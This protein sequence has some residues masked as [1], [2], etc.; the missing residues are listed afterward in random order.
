MSGVA[1]S[2]TAPSTLLRT[3]KARVADDRAS[4]RDDSRTSVRRLLARGPMRLTRSLAFVATL[5]IVPSAALADGLVVHSRE[6]G[7]WTES[8]ARLERNPASEGQTLHVDVRDDAAHPLECGAYRLALDTVGARAFALGRCDPATGMTEVR[9]F[10]RA[11]LFARGPH[12][13]FQALG[14]RIS[15]AVVPRATDANRV[16]TSAPAATVP[17]QPPAEDPYVDVALLPTIS[18]DASGPIRESRV[19]TTCTEAPEIGQGVT[20]DGT[21]LDGSQRP[22][23]LLHLENQTSVRLDISSSFGGEI[24]IYPACPDGLL[25]TSHSSVFGVG[26]QQRLEWDVRSGD[27]YVVIIDAD[28][29]PHR[30]RYVMRTELQ[31]DYLAVSR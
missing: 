29:H 30:G 6:Y 25:E 1:Q 16:G 31:P 11:A 20:V 24:D 9:L 13:S 7:S 23:Y 18:L 19:A 22:V 15:A 4:I 28:I 12:G 10:R 3:E 14:V 21:T 17:P 26:P 27:Y 5:A 2:A 8:I